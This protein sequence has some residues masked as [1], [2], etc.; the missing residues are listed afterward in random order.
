MLFKTLVHSYGNALAGK[1]RPGTDPIAQVLDR[2]EWE[3]FR[4]EALDDISGATVYLLDAAAAEYADSFREDLQGHEFTEDAAK[5]V[6]TYLREVELPAELVWVEHDHAALTASRLKR[7]HDA[8]DGSNPSEF[9]LRGFLFDNRS[10]EHL[11]V[12]LYRTAGRDTGIIIDPLL[13]IL[14]KKDE[15]G[16]PQM[17][18]YLSERHDHMLSFYERAGATRSQF[19]DILEQERNEASY[20]MALAFIVF[21]AISSKETDLLLEKKESLTTSEA[22]TARKFGKTWITNALR[23][24][25]TIRIGEEGR[26]HLKEQAARRA[27]ERDQSE[28][29]LPRAEHW[30]SAHERH[31]KSGK[32]VLVK[33]HRR[34]TAVDPSIPRLVKGPTSR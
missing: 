23:S 26:L 34:G 13:H 20:D 28:G 32:I 24:H 29:R 9:G 31:Y 4:Q 2:S 11:K 16:L 6:G 19:E 10:S 12:T 5:Q 14:F 27:F 25:V 17:G 30:V 33:S 3:G 7:G 1:A 8:E 18:R 22:K 15:D 21:A